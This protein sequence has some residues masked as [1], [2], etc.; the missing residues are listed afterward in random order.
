MK[1]ADVFVIAG[2]ASGDLHASSLIN[3]LKKLSPGISVEAIGGNRLSDAGANL[4]FNYSEVNFVGFAEIAANIKAIRKKISETIKYI[5]T[6]QPK[7]VLLTDFPGFNLK[8]AKEIRKNYKGKIIYYITPQ[9]WAW[10]KSRVKQIRQYI[11]KCLVI[12]PFEKKFFENEGIDASYVGHPLLKPVDDFLE[13]REKKTNPMPVVTLMPGSRVQEV[14]RIMPV[15][16]KTACELI[17]KYKCSVNLLCSE[18]IPDGVFEEF[19]IHPS[20]NRISSASNYET[21]YNSDFVVTKFGTS[22]LECALLGTPFCAVYKAGNINYMLGRMMIRTDFVAL[23]NIILEKEVVKEFI[24]KDFT[25]ENLIGEFLNVMNDDKYRNI[26]LS[27]FFLLRN[28]FYDVAVEKTA[29]QIISE[30]LNN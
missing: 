29:P 17:D 19:S 13:G 11:D 14:R 10:H 18:N 25:K 27:E 15:L 2:E 21:I 26:M 22:T 20:V 8:I 24:Q 16:S 5:V 7:I 12:F 23:V 4:L 30:F 3:G 28:Y 9:V 6:N 1:N